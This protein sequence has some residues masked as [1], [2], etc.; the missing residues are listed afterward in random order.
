MTKRVHS[1]RPAASKKQN[2]D[3]A[4][5]KRA[6]APVRSEDNDR[7]TCS[8]SKEELN[9]FLWLANDE[10][11]SLSSW[12]RYELVKRV[13]AQGLW[14]EAVARGEFPTEMRRRMK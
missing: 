14:D 7:F 12:V 3:G 8:C 5:A 2:A 4:S 11:R 9:V 1:T 13:Q 10:K 6:H